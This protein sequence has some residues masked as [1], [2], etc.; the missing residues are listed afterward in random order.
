M[1]DPR[2]TLVAIIYVVGCLLLVKGVFETGIYK[3]WPVDIIET[4]IMYFNVLAF[5]CLYV[6]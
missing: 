5:C 3:N 4:I 6:V 2:V 1:G